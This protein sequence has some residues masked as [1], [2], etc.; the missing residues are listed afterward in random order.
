MTVTVYW[1]YY[2]FNHCFFLSCRCSVGIGWPIH[3]NHEQNWGIKGPLGYQHSH[4]HS[5]YL[6]FVL[7]FLHFCMEK[8]FLMGF[9]LRE[10]NTLLNVLNI[11]TI[12]KFSWK[13]KITVHFFF[14]KE[15]IVWFI[16]LN[17]LHCS[18]IAVRKELARRN[19]AGSESMK[20][21]VEETKGELEDLKKNQLDITAGNLQTYYLR[22]KYQILGQHRVVWGFFFFF[23]PFS[24]GKYCAF[25]IFIEGY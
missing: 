7:T 16:F 1:G 21:Q 13:V 25:H 17:Y 8:I 23:L 19:Q 11:I 15:R 9:S 10:L 14:L 5:T 20:S 6:I 2:H 4:K 12:E 18:S 3:S 22:M 24:K